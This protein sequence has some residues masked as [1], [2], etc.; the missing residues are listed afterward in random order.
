MEI[1]KSLIGY[2]SMISI[3]AWMLFYATINEGDLFYM[4]IFFIAFCTTLPLLMAIGM[5]M[6]G[7]ARIV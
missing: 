3:I 7:K 1:P 4:F 2:L 6:R 5:I